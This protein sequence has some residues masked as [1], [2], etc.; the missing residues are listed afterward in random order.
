MKQ[1]I[2]DNGVI[3]GDIMWSDNHFWINFGNKNVTIYM[4]TQAIQRIKECK[5]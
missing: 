2:A 1:A 5:R 4:M 3:L